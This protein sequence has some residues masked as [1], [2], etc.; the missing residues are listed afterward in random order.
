[1]KSVVGRFGGYEGALLPGKIEVVEASIRWFERAPA[2]WDY[3][4]TARDN[5]EWPR[6][7]R[8]ASDGS[9]YDADGR[10]TSRVPRMATAVRGDLK[11]D[12]RPTGNTETARPASRGRCGPSR[13][14]EEGCP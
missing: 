5:K 10:L 6:K 14:V 3:G 8:P 9:G 4:M 7:S 13:P 12:G 1:M 11:V 2:K